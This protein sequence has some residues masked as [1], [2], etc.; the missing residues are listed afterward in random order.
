[1]SLVPEGEEM[2]GLCILSFVFFAALLLMISF[3]A[4]RLYNRMKEWRRIDA[5]SK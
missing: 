2:I 4:V 5:E 1:M 3:A